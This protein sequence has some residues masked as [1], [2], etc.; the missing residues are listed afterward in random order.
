ML[1]YQGLPYVPKVIRLELIIRH[2][3]DPLASHF[4]IEKICELIAKKYYWPMLRRNVEAYVKGCDV[5]LAS[6]AIRHKPYGDL[7]LLP[8]PT[9]LWKDLPIDFVTG[10][11]I[12]VDWK[13]DSYDSILVIVDRLTKMIHYELVKV[14]IDTPGLAE[15]IIDVV[16]R[17]HGVLESI[18]TDRGSLFTSKSWCSLCY[19]LGIKRKLSTAFYPQTD[20]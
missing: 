15:V 18:V 6:K 14:T 16:V 7:Q 9:H 17:H 8:I 20:G 19:F 13:G 4:G 10:L 2:H 1:H 11:L 3:D 5:C 12:S